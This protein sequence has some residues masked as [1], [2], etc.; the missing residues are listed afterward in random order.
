MYAINKHNSY[1]GYNDRS[2]YDGQVAVVDPCRYGIEDLYQYPSEDKGISSLFQRC[3]SSRPPAKTHIN[4][5]NYTTHDDRTGQTHFKVNE[6]VEEGNNLVLG[7]WHWAFG[8]W[9]LVFEVKINY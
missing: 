3:R 1:R 4:E 7:V 5:P 2:H 6:A 8:F 9:L